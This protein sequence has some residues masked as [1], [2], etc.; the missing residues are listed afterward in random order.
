LRK[1]WQ[2]TLK[3]K[4]GELKS[5]VKGGTKL[6]TAALSGDFKTV[7]NIIEK[8]K[9]SDALLNGRDEK[10]GDSALHLACDGGHRDI[11]Q[12]LLD[13]VRLFSYES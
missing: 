10:T 6:L 12:Y 8:A 2:S 9:D 11:V 3:K 1:E 5:T 7:K 13:K 4:K